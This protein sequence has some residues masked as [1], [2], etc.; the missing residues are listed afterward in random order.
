MQA[1]AKEQGATILIVTHDNRILDVADRILH[2]EDG[3]ISTFTEAVIAN[4]QHMMGLLAESASRQ[5]LEQA[6]RRDGRSGVP[7]HA[8]GADAAVAAV[9]RGDRARRDRSLPEP[10]RAG[11][12]GI[13]APR[14]RAARC[15]ARVAVPR[16]SRGA[17]S[18]CCASPRTSRP[19]RPC[20]FRSAAASRARRRR[21]AARCASPMPT[22]TR[23][24]TATWTADRVSARARCCAC[25]CTTARA[26][27]SR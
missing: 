3:R 9:P 13:H 15:R 26:T 12:A 19:A 24:S 2:L 22:R 17:A 1:L 5:P 8:A 18:W 25:R 20:A 14:R 16:G 23:A 27:Y 6:G 21:P 4:T 7:P 11:A 10:A